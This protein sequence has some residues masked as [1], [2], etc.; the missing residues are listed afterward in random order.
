MSSRAAEV[1]PAQR[2]VQGGVAQMCWRDHSA[3][4]RHFFQPA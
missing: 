2:R 3:K 4:A 1:K